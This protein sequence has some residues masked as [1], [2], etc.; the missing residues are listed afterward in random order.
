M[1]N[2]ITETAK[3]DSPAE[4]ETTP[5]PTCPRCGDEIFRC[6]SLRCNNWWWHCFG[7]D[8]EYDP[9]MTEILPEN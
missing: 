7:C 4:L 3:A 6:E 9:D 1:A 2:H 8:S 5:E